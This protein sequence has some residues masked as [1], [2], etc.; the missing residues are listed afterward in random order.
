MRPS[1]TLYILK[2]RTYKM[3]YRNK[4]QVIDNNVIDYRTFVGQQ[5][6]DISDAVIAYKRRNKNRVE[7]LFYDICEWIVTWWHGYFEDYIGVHSHE[8]GSRIVLFKL[9]HMPIGYQEFN[10]LYRLVKTVP[11]N[12]SN[13]LNHLLEMMDTLLFRRIYE[14]KYIFE[15]HIFPLFMYCRAAL[16]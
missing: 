8:V 15:R 13:K 3:S 2:G 16:E 10:D 1:L 5:P 14:K 6:E 11:I 7:S 12:H 4:E 9:T